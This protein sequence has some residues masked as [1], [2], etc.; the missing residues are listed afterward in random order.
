RAA[1]AIDPEEAS[2]ILWGEE[3][4]YGSLAHVARVLTGRWEIGATN[5]D[6]KCE[7]VASLELLKRAFGNERSARVED[8]PVRTRGEALAA[9]L[10]DRAGIVV[11]TCKLGNPQQLRTAL[12][13]QLVLQEQMRNAPANGAAVGSDLTG[14]REQLFESMLT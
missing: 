11:P 4:E 6:P 2:R 5:G 14:Q 12:I 3:G 8:R 13:D 7:G 9:Q 10:V 1:Q